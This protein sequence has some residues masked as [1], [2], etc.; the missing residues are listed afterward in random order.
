MYCNATA[1]ELPLGQGAS[2]NDHPA[3]YVGGYPHDMQLSQSAGMYYHATA[4][5]HCDSTGFIQTAGFWGAS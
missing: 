2:F 5:H 4:A 3:G 1:P